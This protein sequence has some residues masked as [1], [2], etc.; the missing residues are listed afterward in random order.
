M[1][2]F[3]CS[4]LLCAKIFVRVPWRD[5]ALDS[6]CVSFD[7]PSCIEH[8]TSCGFLPGLLL[9]TRSLYAYMNGLIYS[10]IVGFWRRCIVHA[11]RDI[12][13]VR[14]VK[15]ALQWNYQ[16]FPLW[17]SFLIS[18]K[19]LLHYRLSLTIALQ[20]LQFLG[21]QDVVSIFSSFVI[22]E[23]ATPPYCSCN[24]T[25]VWRCNTTSMYG[26]ILTLAVS[27]CRYMSFRCP[28]FVYMS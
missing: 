13:C 26:G 19:Q 28:S 27:S 10:W 21:R 1:I 11:W 5:L 18:W 9:Y 20:G 17:L 23:C 8:E 12:G 16:Q 15:L 4:D 14:N 6:S 3:S 7:Y 25:S 24:T 2:W 22:P